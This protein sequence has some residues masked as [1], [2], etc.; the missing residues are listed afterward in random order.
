MAI[1]ITAG[2]IVE[3]FKRILQPSLAAEYA[4]LVYNFVAGAKDF[5]EGRLQDFSQVGFKAPDDRTFQSSS[6]T[7]PLPTS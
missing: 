3:S 7:I 2:G 4:Y 6:S 5:Y 1:P